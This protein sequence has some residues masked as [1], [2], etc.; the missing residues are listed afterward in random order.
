MIDF[1]VVPSGATVTLVARAAMPRGAE[2]VLL[3]D[4]VEVAR[5]K[6]EL[7]KEVPPSA[8]AYRVE[9]HI[10]SAPGQPPVPWLV[11][12]AVYLTP[13]STSAPST[14]APSTEHGAPST[15]IPPFPWRIEKDPASS[16]ILRTSA[17]AV[18]LEYRLADGARNSQFVAL[19]TDVHD[20]SFSAIDL[21][22]KSDRP[23]K[24]SVQVR[25]AAGERWGRSY[26]IDPAGSAI[27]AR[28]AD[29]RPIAAGSN[30]AVP[31]ST[32]VTSIL[33]VADL[34]NAAPGR[35]GRLVVQ[36]S[37]LVK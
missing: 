15:A 5:S 26:Y 16:A 12:N 29:F 6:G 19:A 1:H 23:A 3:R 24:V 8:G 27:Q 2:V 30:S 28:L 36:S 4:G 13:P 32:A 37:A 35:A 9:V 18:E 25:T 17:S 7:R 22:L 31:P 10:P 34:T 33:L 21:S 14:S 20:Q 11:G